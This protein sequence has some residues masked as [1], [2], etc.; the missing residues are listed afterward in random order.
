MKTEELKKE[1]INRINSTE[2]KSLLEDI[3]RLIDPENSG[4]VIYE[5]SFEEKTELNIAR[6][7]VKNGQYFTQ[8][9]VDESMK[10]WLG[11]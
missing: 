6:E 1:L 8:E 4:K 7:E 2:D 10:K 11:E 9:E 3:Y 5:L